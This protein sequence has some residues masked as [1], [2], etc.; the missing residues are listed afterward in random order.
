[1]SEMPEWAIQPD[2]HQGGDAW[3]AWRAKGL[4]ASDAPIVMGVSPWK[5][6][7]QLWLNKTGQVKDRFVGNAATEW[8]NK[9]EPVIR[10]KLEGKTGLKFPPETFANGIFLA[11]MDGWSKQKKQGAE[12]K[13]VGIGDFTSAQLKEVPA[14]YEW[15][16]VQQFIATDCKI[17]WFAAYYCPI[18]S[19]I[20]K[21]ELAYFPTYRNR[22]KEKEYITEANK[23][24]QFVMTK[25]P[26]PLTDKD[27]AVIKGTVLAVLADKYKEQTEAKQLADA[28]V[29]HTKAEIIEWAKNHGHKK[30]ECN[31]LSIT[32]VTKK[33]KA[34]TSTYYK[35]E[36]R[37]SK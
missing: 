25:N 2:K 4:G 3:H 7:Y 36:V 8:G 37:G 19:D 22:E 18:D 5:T 26:P 13:F 20:E 16:L 24:W 14:K 35:L 10:R 12:M 15:Q 30:I 21:G 31:G 9:C 33:L 6:P 17:I 34:G 28:R 1:M 29:E 27:T 23:F 32:R 11:S